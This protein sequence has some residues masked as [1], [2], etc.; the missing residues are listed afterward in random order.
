MEE[1][2]ESEDSQDLLTKLSLNED[3]KKSPIK[4]AEHLS[5]FKVITKD[6]VL[7]ILAKNS[8]TRTDVDNR[9]IA[10]YLSKNY[11]YFQK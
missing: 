2:E 8:K 11:E 4:L 6:M 7:Q 1:E 10:D 5:R 9:I 3:T